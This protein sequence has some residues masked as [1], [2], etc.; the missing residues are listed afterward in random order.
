[1]KKMSL[2]I[3]LCFV[4][5]QPEDCAEGRYINEMF[6]VNVQSN[7]QYGENINQTLLGSDYNQTLYMDIYTPSGDNIDDRPLIFL[8]LVDHLLVGQKQTQI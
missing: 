2:I 3:L 5:A 8:C 7:V 1:M 6:D 4:F